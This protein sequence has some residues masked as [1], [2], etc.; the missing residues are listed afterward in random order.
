MKETSLAIGP[1]PA[2]LYGEPSHQ[3]WLYIH[4]K[5]GCKEEAQPF[6]EAA[7]PR[8]W[9]VL[10]IDLPGHGER[11]G[12]APAFVPW[13]VVPEL[14]QLLSYAQARWTHIAL[15]CTSLGAWF[16]MLAAGGVRL[17]HAL[18]VSPVLDMERL[19]RDMMGWAGVSAGQ[20]EQ[21]GEIPTEF[22]ETLSWRYLQYAMSH[23]IRRWDT[24]TSI[25]YGGGD[26]LTSRETVQSFQTRF[27]CELSVL[28]GGGHWLHTPEQL[29][30][31]R[32]WEAAHI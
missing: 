10:S 21:E 28:E 1:M 27:G 23:P 20:L 32:S 13:D 31:L 15:R 30:A 9:Q 6:A 14:K 4:G 2:I 12:P 26:H 18:F 8:G 24:P 3:V 5:C 16:S 19:I 17:D 25:L 22:G 29:A 11:T 7:C